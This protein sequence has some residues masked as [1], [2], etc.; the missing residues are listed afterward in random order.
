MDLV[1]PIFAMKDGGDSSL[2]TGLTAQGINMTPAALLGN[3][4]AASNNT[5]NEDDN[6]V[7]LNTLHTPGDTRSLPRTPTPFNLAANCI[8]SANPSMRKIGSGK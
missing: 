6:E 1:N 7:M 3:E 2:C 8:S 5:N 4:H